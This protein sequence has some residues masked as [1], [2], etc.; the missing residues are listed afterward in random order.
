M[1]PDSETLLAFAL[2]AAACVACAVID[3]RTKRIPN[4]ITFPVAAALLLLHGVFSGT[5]GLTSSALGLAG[6]F[7]VFLIPHLFGVLGAGDV[8]LMAMV[9]AGLGTQALLTAVLFTSIAGG[10]QFFV[11]LAWMRLAGTRKGRGYRLCYGPAIA[12]GAL[13][14][15]ALHLAG[16]PYLSLVIPQF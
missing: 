14:T 7:I 5:T 8:K 15:M 16:Q 4:A 13:A 11:W 9:G 6:G 1:P 2:T 10:A 3:I 12:A